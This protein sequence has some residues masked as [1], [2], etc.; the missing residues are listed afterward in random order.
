MDIGSFI[1]KNVTKVED[2]EVQVRK[3]LGT[4]C[5]LIFQ[6]ESKR[7]EALI[8]SRPETKNSTAY[9]LVTIA[10]TDL[11]R[12]HLTAVRRLRQRYVDFRSVRLK[13]KVAKGRIIFFNPLVVILPHETEDL[14][15]KGDVTAI[16]IFRDAILD[17]FG[18]LVS[19]WEAAWSIV[20]EIKRSKT[21]GAI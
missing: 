11:R 3:K 17:C 8:N 9:T 13:P 5:M 15:E 16:E 1:E 2:F 19:D 21:K 18:D 4:D 7:F 6:S 12:K 20:D 14:V 10:S